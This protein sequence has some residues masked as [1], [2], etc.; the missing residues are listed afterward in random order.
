MKWLHALHAAATVALVGGLAAQQQQLQALD[1]RLQELVRAERLDQEVAR[2]VAAAQAE[3][4]PLDAEA[5]AEIARAA[6]E[7]AGIDDEEQ[8]LSM[9]EDVVEGAVEDAV[10]R[11]ADQKKQADTDRWVQQASDGMR[12][13]LEEMSGEYGLDEDQI[14][15]AMIPLEESL[16][17]SVDLK[18]RMNAEEMSM[19]EAIEE[20]RAIREDLRAD[21]VA[22]IGEEATEALGPKIRQGRGWDED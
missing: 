5:R 12:F 14:E 16:L 8:V 22:A 13:V 2:Q 3:G 4:R 11:H 21:L 15:A 17:D 9:V 1:G 10:Q 6:S 20:G 19:R 18:E 7:A